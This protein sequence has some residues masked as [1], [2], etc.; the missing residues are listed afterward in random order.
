MLQLVVVKTV[1]VVEPLRDALSPLAS[2]IEAAFVYGS[3]ADGSDRAGSDVDLLVISE[4][5]S[6]ADVYAALEDA[7]QILARPVNPT[8]M[9]RSDWREKVQQT[10]SF[11]SR[12]AAR[13]KLTVLGAVDDLA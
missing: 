9:T 11:A 2:R 1:A 12:V 7:A 10:D 3:V 13:P 8:V 6:Y 4:D 5:L